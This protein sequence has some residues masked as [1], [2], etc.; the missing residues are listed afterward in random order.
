MS[1]A[2]LKNKLD[3][4]TTALVKSTATS[5]AKTGA[6]TFTPSNVA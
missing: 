1:L 4:C 3:P 5:W 2:F 6:V